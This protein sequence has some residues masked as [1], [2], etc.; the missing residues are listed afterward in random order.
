DAATMMV[1]FLDDVRAGPPVQRIR[2]TTDAGTRSVAVKPTSALQQVALPEGQTRRVRITVTA[3]AGPATDA[4]VVG[5]RLVG[6]PGVAVARTIVVPEDSAQTTPAVIALARAAGQVDACIP[7]VFLSPCNQA[8]A[9]PGEETGP[10]DRTFT[11]AGPSR[12]SLTGVA[13]PKA[14]KAL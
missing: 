12:F 1:R 11:I 13:R 10:L 4:S 9:R 14:G 5:I 2:V 6:L 7:S 8:I 3:L